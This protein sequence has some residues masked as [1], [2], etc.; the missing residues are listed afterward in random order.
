[1]LLVDYA[2]ITPIDNI[3]TTIGDSFRVT[4]RN[5]PDRF[6]NRR[7]LAD[8]WS[9]VVHPETPPVGLL[10]IN[11]SGTNLTVLE[12]SGDTMRFRFLL[13]QAA[14]NA[15]RI[16]YLISCTGVF[17]QD[18]Q[19]F[20][21]NN[22]PLAASFDGARGVA[23]IRQGAQSAVIDEIIIDPASGECIPNVL[24]TIMKGAKI[25]VAP[26]KKLLLNNNVII[27]EN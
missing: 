17:G 14:P 8:S 19:V 5:V 25:T 4:L 22:Q 26:G 13:P 24:L 11:V 15:V 20:F 18:Y 27:K 7:L 2:V 21:E 23:F 6:G 10:P 3:S 9:F 16:N 12:N 1:M